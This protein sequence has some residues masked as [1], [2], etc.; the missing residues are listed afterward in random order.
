VGLHR[1][2]AAQAD[3]PTPMEVCGSGV[4][5]CPELTRILQEAGLTQVQTIFGGAAVC[6]VVAAGLALVLF[7]SAHTRRVPV[8]RLAEPLL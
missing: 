5:R 6:C 7:R 1:Y 4:S 3:L 2:Y 8:Q